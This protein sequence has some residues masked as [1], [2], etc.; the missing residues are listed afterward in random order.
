MAARSRR[1]GR[2]RPLESRALPGR[3]VLIGGAF[4]V[5]AGLVAAGC[6]DDDPGSELADLAPPDAPLYTEVS[7][8]PADEQ[9]ETIA[10]LSEQVGGIEDP[11]AA[12]T[13]QV[14]DLFA[15]NGL[16]VS[17]EKDVEG[18]LGEHVGVFVRSFENGELDVPE[19]AA[20]FE[21][22]DTGEAEAALERLAGADSAV[23]ETRTYGGF[24][25]LFGADDGGFA[26]GLVDDTLVLGTEASFKVAVDATEG[27]SLSESDEYR[28]RI[29]A[30]GDD[31]LAKVFLDPGS[32]IEAA[33]ASEDISDRDAAM[34]R[35]LLAEQLAA[36][37]AAALSLQEEAASFDIVTAVD[38]GEAL[39]TD[40]GLLEGLPS[41]SWLGLGISDLG[42][43]IERSIDQLETSGLP[44]AGSLRAAVRRRTGLD[45]EEVVDWLG[46][47]SAFVGGTNPLGFTA[48]V[49]AET[50]DA[51]APRP[52]LDMLQR[53]VEDEFPEVPIGPAPAGAS[54]GFSAGLPGGLP[55]G[56]E[57]GVLD[58]TVVAALGVSA[59]EALDPDETLADDDRFAAAE[60][61]LDGDFAPFLY[62][63]VP[64]FL[65]VAELGGAAEDPGYVAAAPFVDLLGYA[66][67]GTDTSDGL[68]VMRLTVGFDSE[69]PQ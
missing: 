21:V 10:R 50:A 43:L 15:E 46:D 44:G 28:D 24:E 56:A 67:A 29:D 55:G 49:L 34:I 16:D 58:S 35:P 7:V 27:E 62:L 68:A 1:R 11:G 33:I 60:D 31:P 18:W 14:D 20:L 6:G 26:V 48:G 40:A 37:V 2:P 9:A 23:E 52:V 66:I 17:Y 5:A 45:L 42:P 3:L 53:A 63:D 32:V 61:A 22:E 47:G 64:S 59:A 13:D 8:R 41:G 25:Y 54:D 39:E 65:A 19:F 4:A 69:P 38:D 30:I 12:L 57:V 36:P 51:D